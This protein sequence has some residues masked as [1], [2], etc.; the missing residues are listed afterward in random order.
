MIDNSPTPMTESGNA[1][2]RMGGGILLLSL[3]ALVAE[4][5]LIRAFDV[6]F[7]PN[8]AYMIITS[9]LFGFG[10]AGVY[11]VLRPLRETKTMNSVISR[12]A[13]LQAIS[14]IAILP[15]LN[16][17]PFDFNKLATD[18]ITQ[19]AYFAGIYL[20][21]VLP[22]FLVGLVLAN[23]F[24]AYAERAQFLYFSDLSGAA[25]GSVLVVL[26]IPA[27]G[28]GGLLFCAAAF[29]MF[30]SSL[31]LKS[32]AW[33]IISSSI[34]A[35]LIIIPLVYS[36]KY[37]DFKEHQD[38]R[39]I[40]TAR[41][42]GRIERTV[43]DPVS[44]LDVINYGHRRTIAYDGGSQESTF[45]PFDGDFHSLRAN[46]SDQVEPPFW[47]RGV[48]ASHY[49]KRDTG[50]RVLVIGS[51]GGQEAKAALMYGAEH[52][53]GVEMVGSVVGLGK[54]EYSSY[55][56]DLFLHPA[57]DV[58]VGEGRSFL[59]SREEKY[60]IVQ[61][62]SNHTSSAVASGTGALQTT[63]LQTVQAYKEFFTH[64]SD[65]GILHINH[66]AYPKMVTTA[67]LAWS[68]LGWKDFRK[69][70][71]VFTRNEDDTLPTFLVKMQP[72]TAAEVQDL[73]T[74]FSEHFPWDS[75]TYVL[76]EDPLH[77]ED[78]WLADEFYVGEHPGGLV[79]RI[80]YGTLPATDNQPFFN[81]L[82]NSIF[83]TRDD[84]QKLAGSSLESIPIVSTAL[85]VTGIVSLF[86]GVLFILVPLLFSS[87]GRSDWPNKKQALVYFSC[88]GAGFIIVEFVLIQ[89]FM[90]LIGSPLHV[91]STVISVLLFGAGI[92]SF[93]SAKLKISPSR[94]WYIPF[95]G[96]IA[97]CLVIVA[98]RSVVFGL[99]LA[100]PISV[101]IFIAAL[102][103]FPLGFF[104]GMPFPLG[105]LALKERPKGSI[106]WA[107]G[108]N[109]LFT[110]LGSLLGV[111]LSIRWGFNITLSIALLIYVL[112][113]AMFSR[114]RRGTI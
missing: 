30:A 114:V 4:L 85:T 37:I 88:L 93:A 26:L 109:G 23:I 108:M 100:S 59:R 48:L 44:K 5:S 87:I 33:S 67:S 63:Y 83:L 25:I 61:I 9:A 103:I 2:T 49:L 46:I 32:R 82:R 3:A 99:F 102:F 54:S 64:L 50:A 31:F 6:L 42:Q 45:Y 79:G 69:H 73:K 105:I 101:R 27:I 77:P 51:A 71:V 52:V 29:S 57:V 22:F 34:A 81:F 15:I 7:Y 89:I 112:A 76:A 1:M 8:I 74:F 21:L 107:W 36:P 12:W 24:S 94:G 90:H 111:V 14:T 84:L 65:D 55:I 38:K 75:D 66:H 72:W 40:K 92:G 104:L 43:W 60:D 39:G 28:P 58:I 35:L 17:L 56:G 11:T 78:S 80:D 70:V 86:Y 91:V 53:T 97:T 19:A 96:V 47:Q 41:E 113:F 18:P 98:A 10:L 13:V 62:F 106:A 16:W 95:L 110:V 20:V 68:E